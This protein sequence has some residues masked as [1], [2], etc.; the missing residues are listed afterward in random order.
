MRDSSARLISGVGS[1][2]KYVFQG[3]QARLARG[4]VRPLGVNANQR[5]SATCAQQ[6]PAAVGE[7]EL[8]SIVR[9]D[10]LHLDARDLAGF[11]RFH[12]AQYP[13]PILLVGLTVEV[14]VVP[15]VRVRADPLLKSGEDLRQRPAELDDHVCEQE[16][17]ENP[18]ALGSGARVWDPPHP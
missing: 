12:R 16:A 18:I 4:F 14:D 8:E 7:I 1:E 9:A 13:K 15:G 10:P 11:M 3:S 6:Y 5:L 17:A 2:A